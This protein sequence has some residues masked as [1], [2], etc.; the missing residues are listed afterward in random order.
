MEEK[1][2]SIP[3]YDDRY[4]ISSCGRLRN[5]HGLIMKPM[6]C[7]N[8]YLAA[9][10]WNH[11]R[12]KKISIHR[13]VA[14]AFV[15]N[16]LGFS[17]VNHKDED[18]ANNNASNL[19]WCSHSYNMNYGHVKENISKAKTGK[20]LTEEHKRKCAAASRGKRWVSNGERETL[21]REEEIPSYFYNGYRIGRLKNV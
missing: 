14:E 13:L 6:V 17:E 15:D 11:N 5:S 3:G 20:H 16:P 8:G 2:K 4:A 9:C 21:I 12:Q 7:T 1:W 18:K 10:L 19:E